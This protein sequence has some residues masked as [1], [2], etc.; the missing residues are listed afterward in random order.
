MAKWNMIKD[1][2]RSTKHTHKTKDRVTRTPIQIGGKPRCS[3][4]TYL[5]ILITYGPIK[6]FSLSTFLFLKFMF[7]TYPSG[8]PE[9][10]PGFQWGSCYSIFSFICMF[11][12]SLFVLLYF[13]FWPLWLMLSVLL[14]YTDSD[15]PFGIFKLFLK[16]SFRVYM[17]PLST[18]IWM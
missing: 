4:K 3:E 15:C 10:T 2:Q 6:L 18:I 13:F 17:L 7:Q 1:N 9:F 16:R 8:A 14:R 5:T 11:C 12:R